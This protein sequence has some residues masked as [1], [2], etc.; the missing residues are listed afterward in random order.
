LN[1]LECKGWMDGLTEDVCYMDIAKYKQKCSKFLATG[2]HAACHTDG[3]R[4]EYV[5]EYVRRM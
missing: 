3:P 4:L 2:Y 5:I 1:E